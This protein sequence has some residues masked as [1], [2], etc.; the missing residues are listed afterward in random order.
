VTGLTRAAAAELGPD[1]IRV[2]A[3]A[4]STVDTEGVRSVVSEEGIQ[5]RIGQTPLG[6]LGTT[7]DIARAVRYFACEDSSFVTGQ[8][9]TVDGG[10][11]TSL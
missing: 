10:L 6:R 4:P 9:L 3:I 5:A 1:N 2:N 11:A 8:L 7:E